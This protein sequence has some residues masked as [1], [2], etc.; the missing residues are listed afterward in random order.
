MPEGW[1]SLPFGQGPTAG[2]NLLALF[3]DSGL[4]MDPEG[5][6][7]AAPMR[8]AVAFAGLAKQG[9]EVKLFVVKYLTTY[10]EIDPYGVGSEAEITRSTTQSGAAN[11][12]RERSDEWA[13]RAGGGEMVL[14][15]DY[16]TGARGW[17]AGELFPHSAREPEFSRIYRFEQLADLV[18]STAIGKPANGA[19]ELT[20]DIAALAPVLDGSHEVIAVIDVPVYVR[21][22]FL[23]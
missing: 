10:P 7:I 16:T 4:E 18:M 5:K 14:S 17:S 6:P 19:F 23:P 13:V 22:V 3:I 21:E 15:L 12:P 1:T 8:R 2:A 9:E 11:G 20:S